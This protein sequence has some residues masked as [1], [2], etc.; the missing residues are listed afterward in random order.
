M[1]ELCAEPNCIQ[2][3]TSIDKLHYHTLYFHNICRLCTVDNTDIADVDA[4]IKNKD[5]RVCK[6]NSCNS[7]YHAKQ[8]N[9]HSRQIHQ[10]SV[11]LKRRSNNQIW[12]KLRV[13]DLFICDNGCKFSNCN[14]S[15]FQRHYKTCSVGNPGPVTDNNNNS[16]SSSSYNIRFEKR[17]SQNDLGDDLVDDG[18]STFDSRRGHAV[19]ART[20]SLIDPAEGDFFVVTLDGLNSKLSPMTDS[21][22]ACHVDMKII[23]CTECKVSLYPT[24]E[25]GLDNHLRQHHKAQYNKDTFNNILCFL[26]DHKDGN[27]DAFSGNTDWV[28]LFMTPRDSLSHPDYIEGVKIYKISYQ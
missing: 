6:E 27:S 7:L 21:P 15:N 13:G 2:S 11:M 8:H 18:N 28:R 1:V 22:L 17:R 26:H 14:G 3:Y 10:S 9:T 20:G 19:R 12:S 24:G 23:I 4:H 5:H 16:S 25:E